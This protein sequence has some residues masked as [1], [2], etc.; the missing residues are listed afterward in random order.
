MEKFKIVIKTYAGLEEDLR[1]ELQEKLGLKGKVLKRAVTVEGEL[2]DIY[3]IN[4]HIGTALKVLVTIDEFRIF[5]EK[6]YYRYLKR[7]KWTDYLDVNDSFVVDSTIFTRLFNNSQIVSLKAKDAICDFFRDETGERPNVDKQNPDVRI[8]IHI[9]DQQVSVLLDSSGKSLH[10]RGYKRGFHVAP[11]SEV[12]AYDILRKA[13][14]KNKLV[15]DPMCG[16]GSFLTEAGLIK[17]NVPPN[18][19]REEFAFMKWKNFDSFTWEN[20]RN[21]AKM[22]K[23]KVDLSLYGSDISPKYQK[24]SEENIESAHLTSAAEISNEDF[25][26]MIPPGPEGVLV[27][28]PP[29]NERL[30]E[31]DIAEFYREIGDRLKQEWT[32]WDVWMISSNLSALKFVGLKTSRRFDLFNGSLQCKLVKYEMYKGSKK[33]KYMS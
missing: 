1:D 22:A 9:A 7:I 20:I 29:Y 17:A 8:S 30:R 28:N 26:D 5:N 3:L 18:F 33:G 25:F 12:L 31:D 23:E 14:V 4:L 10:I 2:E 19:F 21:Q 16:S 15:V 32:G 13:K 27:F 24:I 11:L 6:Q